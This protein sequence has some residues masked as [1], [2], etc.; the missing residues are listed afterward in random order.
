MRKYTHELN[1]RLVSGL[2][3]DLGKNADVQRLVD[4]SQNG[5]V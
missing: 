5:G 1:L 4:F 3:Q 2:I